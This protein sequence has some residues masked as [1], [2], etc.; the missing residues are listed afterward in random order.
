MCRRRNIPRSMS[1][2]R[3]RAAVRSWDRPGSWI[4]SAG[5][6]RCWPTR[7][8]QAYR[9]G[10]RSGISTGS[11]RIS[12]I[13]PARGCGRRCASPPPGRWEAAP[14]MRSRRPPALKCCTTPSWCTTI[15]RTAAIQGAALPPCI[16]GSGCRSP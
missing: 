5:T 14:K 10:S 8:R 2:T 4:A 7:W 9:H 3:F 13:A 16:A 15:S 11:S 1:P 12:S 6:A